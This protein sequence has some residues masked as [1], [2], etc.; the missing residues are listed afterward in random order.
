MFARERQDAIVALVSQHGRVT[1]SELAEN[2]RVTPDCIR[3]DL[4]RLDGEGMLRC[5]AAP[6][7]SQPPRSTTCEVV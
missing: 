2:F 3:K 5:T 7:A 1:V 6:P 4:R